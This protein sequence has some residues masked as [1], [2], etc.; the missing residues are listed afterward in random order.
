MEVKRFGNILFIPGPSKGRYPHSNS[1][2]IDDSKKAL[3]DAGS[4]ESFLRSL[5]K[6]RSVDMLINSHYHEDHFMFN[7]LFSFADLYVHEAEAP[8]YRSIRNLLDYYGLLGTEYEKVWNDVFIGNFNYR[9]REPA[10]TFRDGDVLDFGKTRMIVIHT[11]GHSPGHCSFYFPEEGVLFLGDLDMTGFGPWY[12]DRVSDIDDTIE[13]V[14]RLMNIPA[15]VFISSHETGIIEG[16]IAGPA[17]AYLSV[18]YSREKKLLDC[19][20]RPQTF[21]EIAQRWIMYGRPREPKFFF[22]FAERA[23]VRKHL[24]RLEK[25]KAVK[26]LDGRYVLA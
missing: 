21:D 1:L 22:E 9:E 26:C 12:G 16:D 18:I 5:Q 10:E 11:P 17:E 25:N 19:L 23:L 2:Y 4:D 15:R 20:V 13:S 7:Y 14:H 3:I 24:E 8:C 6:D